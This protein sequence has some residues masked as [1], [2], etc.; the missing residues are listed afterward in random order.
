MALGQMQ[1]EVS[2]MSDERPL[3]NLYA[4]HTRASHFPTIVSPSA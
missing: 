4:G 1:D 2:G 3:T